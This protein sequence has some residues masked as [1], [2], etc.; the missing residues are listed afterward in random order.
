MFLYFVARIARFR[1]PCFCEYYETN[2]LNEKHSAIGE[3]KHGYFDLL[4]YQLNKLL[5]K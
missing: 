3:H 5:K 4:A 2:P 1:I